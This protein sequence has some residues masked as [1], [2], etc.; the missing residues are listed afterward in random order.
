METVNFGPI[1]LLHNF[2]GEWGDILANGLKSGK[3]MT[4]NC[5]SYKENNNTRFS[6][7]F[8]RLLKSTSNA[9]LLNVWKIL[10]SEIAVLKFL[11]LTK[12]LEI[13]ENCSKKYWHCPL[14]TNTSWENGFS[15]EHFHLSFNISGK[16]YISRLCLFIMWR[17]Y[18]QQTVW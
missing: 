14:L 10:V 3:L 16:Q 13:M 11:L 4:L 7:R 8:G 9:T 18:K 15:L 17:Y 1:K 6:L 12:V 2:A 5:H